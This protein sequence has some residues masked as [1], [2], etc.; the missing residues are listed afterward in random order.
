MLSPRDEWT[1]KKPAIVP[2]RGDKFDYTIL[3]PDGVWKDADRKPETE[4]PKADKFL[5]AKITTEGFDRPDEGELLV[6]VLD[7]PGEP[8][9][10]ARRYVE[11]EMN[12]DTENRGTNTFTKLEG[13]PEGDPTRNTVPANTPVLR[14]RSKNDRSREYSWLI[15]L[16]AIRVGDKVVAVHARCPWD[17]RP[18]FEAK[19]IQIAG[20]LRAGR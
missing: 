9:E 14:L 3:D 7:E 18:V 8:I 12:R 15:A 16:S 19:F 2:H 10:V 5:T 20:S 17:Q 11:K 4:D 1:E 6:Y 13:E